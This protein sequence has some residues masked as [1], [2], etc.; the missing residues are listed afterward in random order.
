MN[1]K[2]KQVIE[3]LSASAVVVSLLFVGY[4]IRQNTSAIRIESYNEFSSRM[5]ELLT[6]IAENERLSGLVAEVSSGKV[7][8]D[9]DD[10]DRISISF[11]QGA[12][13]RNWEGLYRSIEEGILPDS[14]LETIGTGSLTNNDYFR[15]TWPN[16]RPLY[17]NDFIAFFEG[18]SWNHE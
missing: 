4:E 3:I 8:A 16:T 17:S 14:L 2:S 13:V 7:A 5:S 11:I 15:G 12:A 9:F 10:R 1:L 6:S 18:L